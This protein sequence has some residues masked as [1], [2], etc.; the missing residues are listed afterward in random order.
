MIGAA[1]D[2]AWLAVTVDDEGVGRA[3]GGSGARHRAVPPG[4]ERARVA[5]PRHRAS[6]C[7]SAGGSSRPTAVGSMLADRPDGRAG[8]RVRFTL[9]LATADRADAGTEAADG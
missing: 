4:L 2:G 7:S 3:R 1:V 6:G 9:P 8:T 5:H